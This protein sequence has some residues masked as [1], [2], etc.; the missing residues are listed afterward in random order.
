MPWGMTIGESASQNSS[1]A[2]DS[3][4]EQYARRILA[5]R[6]EAKL[7][8]AFVF[9]SGCIIPAMTFFFDDLSDGWKVV[10][11]ACVPFSFCVL[12]SALAPETIPPTCTSAVVFHFALSG[13]VSLDIARAAYFSGAFEPRAQ[14]RLNAAMACSAACIV[15]SVGIMQLHSQLRCSWRLVRKVIILTS[16]IRL[17]EV[18]YA[19]AWITC[20]PNT[21]NAFI[22][23]LAL[24]GVGM[25]FSVCVRMRIHKTFGNSCVDMKHVPQDPK[26]HAVVDLEHVRCVGLKHRPGVAEERASAECPVASDDGLYASGKLPS[27]TGSITSAGVSTV[28]AL[29]TPPSVR[30]GN[31]PTLSNS[32]TT[33]DSWQHSSLCG[34]GAQTPS[35]HGGDPLSGLSILI[36][37]DLKIN[38]KLLI[39]RLQKICKD[40]NIQ[41]VAS[42][43]EAVE[44]IAAATDPIGACSTLEGEVPAYDIVIL[45]ND[46]GCGHAQGSEIVV[47]LRKWELERT[48]ATFNLSGRTVPPR[49]MLIVSW[50]SASSEASF[51]EEALK[52]GFDLVWSKGAT[53]PSEEELAEQLRMALTSLHLW[54]RRL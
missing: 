13:V 45:D 4:L 28:T 38:R 22:I 39:M 50:S 34:H 9:T 1:A 15:S 18:V 6:I 54:S 49:R 26:P 52:Q 42:G 53:M 5:L 8:L 3:S 17:L 23:N 37:D 25:A 30:P 14:Q 20:T 46:F 27:E 32:S 19:R 31:S 24:L 47:Q 21:K 7:R 2:Q 33:S 48:M 44:V 51:R 40:S 35:P 12:L 41:G 29:S 11:F 43:E 10:W 36:A 16:A